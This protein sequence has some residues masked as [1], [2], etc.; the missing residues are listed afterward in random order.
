[1]ALSA[2]ER[3]MAVARSDRLVTVW[4]VATGNELRRLRG[5]SADIARLA[6]S[7]DGHRL[8]SVDADHNVNVWDTEPANDPNLLLHD[9]II[10]YL[11]LSPDG[12]TLAV[13]DPNFFKLRLWDLQAKTA[14]DFI[15]DNKAEPAFSPDGR[16][17]AVWKFGGPTEV[18]LW[19]RSRSVSQPE[20]T[21]PSAPNFGHQLHFS[22][23][24]R[25]LA[26]LG[27]EE[28]LMLW[29]VATRQPIVSLPDHVAGF[30]VG[31]APCFHFSLQ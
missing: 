7:A 1:M 19:D 28:K 21:I 2:D 3:V 17:L 12:Q 8:V 20:C 30:F 10:V 5:H 25:I 22:P 4:D 9:G 31:V 26:F 29:D 15:N 11:A 23:D 16:W 27:P 18:E 13:S 6:I 14:S 24:S